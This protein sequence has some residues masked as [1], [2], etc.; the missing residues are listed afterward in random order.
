MVFDIDIIAVTVY[1]S[2]FV[3]Y[4]RLH[5]YG[6]GVAVCLHLRGSYDLYGHFAQPSEHDRDADIAVLAG[7]QLQTGQ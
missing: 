1:K 4:L 3:C 7:L 2:A 6:S 5:I